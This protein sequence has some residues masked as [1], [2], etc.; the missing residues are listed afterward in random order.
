NM[1]AAADLIKHNQF[2]IALLD[3]SLP[4]SSGIDSVITLDR[5]VPDTPIVVLSGMTDVNT[6]METISLGAQDYL[7]KGEFDEKLLYKTIQYS[8]ERKRML[9]NLRQ[10]NERYELVNKATLDT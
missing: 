4:D 8:I 3:L 5:L 9:E 2:D 1:S 10:S 7:V 6:A